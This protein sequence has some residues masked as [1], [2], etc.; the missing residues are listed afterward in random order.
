M[1]V[2]DAQSEGIEVGTAVHHTREDFETVDLPFHLSIAP[3]ADQSGP[4]R[5]ILLAKT[6]HTTDQTRQAAGLNSVYPCVGVSRCVLRQHGRNC[7]A[8]V[9]SYVH[10]RMKLASVRDQS[11]LSLRSFIGRRYN[12]RRQ[13]TH[14]R[15]RRLFVKV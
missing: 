5:L 6:G 7:L 10:V 3:G 1:R 11:V 14:C 12:Q 8:Q 4:D 13:G 2:H 15:H 9:R